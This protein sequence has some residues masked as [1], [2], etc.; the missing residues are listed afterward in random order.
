[1]S[2]NRLALLFATS[3]H[4]GVDRIVANLLPEFGR[5]AHEFD[6]LRI[7]GHGPYLEKLPSNARD[8]RLPAAHR[9]TVLPGLVGYLRREQP[10]ALLTASHR[11][12]R[13]ALQARWL[14]RVPTRVAIRMGMTLTGQQ[15]ILG[16]RKGRRLIRSMRFWYPRAD[17]VICP[18]EGLGRELHELA[19]VPRE[20]LHVIPNPI[21]T[22]SFLEQAREPLDDPWF[23]DE[24]P[25]VILGAGSLEPRKDFATL[26]RAF[27]RLRQ[28]RPARLVILGEGRERGRLEALAAELGISDDVRLPGF[29]ANPYRWMSRADAFALTSLREGSGAVLVE[30]LAC[31]TPVVATDC[32]VGPGEILQGGAIGPLI[33]MGDEAGIA[34]GLEQALSQPPTAGAL[35]AAAEPFRAGHS[36]TAYLAALG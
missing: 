27:A 29:E 4:S 26:I 21:V 15:E 28:Q 10:A 33:A 2:R 6:L 9:N 7:K 34:A 35:R 11:L 36:A 23:T 3:G 13:A 19:G 22:D 5:T 24:G 16:P 14:A 31:G 17:A 25:P 20:R 12:N 32:P 8:I 1:M 30:A 18:S